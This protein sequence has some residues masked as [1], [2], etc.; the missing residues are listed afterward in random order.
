MY[1]K[2]WHKDGQGALLQYAYGAY[3]AAVEPRFFDYAVSLADRGMVFAIAHV[4]GG[5][6]LGRDWYDQGHLLHKMNTFNDFVDVTRGL[7]AQG[8]ANKDRV[9]ALGGSGGGTLMGASPTWRHRTTRRF[10]QSCRSWTL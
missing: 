2:D 7:V 6:E 1:R 10:W 3:A 9:A 5:N 8:Y 4:R